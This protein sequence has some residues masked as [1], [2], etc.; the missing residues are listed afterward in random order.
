MPDL[1]LRSLYPEDLDQLSRIESSLTGCPRRAFLEKRLAVSTANLGEVFLDEIGG[2]PLDPQTMPDSFITCAALDGK[3]LAGYGFARILE[4]EFGARSAIV[5]LDDIGVAPDCQGKGIGKMVIAG[6]EQRMGKR[7]IRTLRTQVVWPNLSM[8]SFF[9]SS[10]FALASGQIIERDTSP[11]SEDIAE[12]A[13][14]KMDG[15]WQVH[16]G[17]GGNYHDKLARHRVMVRPLRWE[18]LAAVDRIDA[19]LTGLDRSAYCAAKFR[20]VL[21]E[22]GIRV[23]MVAEDDGIVTGFVMARTDFGEFGRVDKA[24]V[25]DTIGVHPDYGSS[26]IGHALLCQ[27]LINLSTL[28]VESLRT[29][30]EHENFALRNFL[31]RRGFKPSQRLLLIKE[32]Q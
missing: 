30:V 1:T 14:V 21:D 6:I 22:S 17:T 20:E 8:I 32:V 2:M 27:L 16:S 23:S 25:L 4:G 9:A 26:G 7:N 15:M 24:A 11:L 13:P 5:E 28:Q 19:K 12:V 29:K 18:D 3:K 31:F 10:G